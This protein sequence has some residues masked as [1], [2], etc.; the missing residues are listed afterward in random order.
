MYSIVPAACSYCCCCCWPVSPAG[1]L[2]S[3]SLTYT[4]LWLAVSVLPLP[5]RLWSNAAV[6]RVLYW[7]PVCIAWPFT[8]PCGQIYWPMLSA[9]QLCLPTLD[10]TI[11]RH[12]L[13]SNSHLLSQIQS[14]I[15][16]C[17]GRAVSPKLC[18]YIG[19][20]L[21]HICAGLGV[22]TSVKAACSWSSSHPKAAYMYTWEIY[23]V[24]TAIYPS[25]PIFPFLPSVN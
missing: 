17:L 9:R 11:L 20:L 10:A 12:H 23:H 24:P 15:L 18:Y 3:A 8:E 16:L 25:D 4:E 22:F 6:Y 19:L 2:Q 1:H 13:A 14:S 7:L 21:P 5:E